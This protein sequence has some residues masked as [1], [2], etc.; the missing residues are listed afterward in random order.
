MDDTSEKSRHAKDTSEKRRHE[1]DSKQSNDNDPLDNDAGHI[2][3]QKNLQGSYYPKPLGD[4]LLAFGP[5]LASYQEHAVYL[6]DWNLN[7]QSQKAFPGVGNF[8]V[9][10]NHWYNGGS[11]NMVIGLHARATGKSN[12]VLGGVANQVSG[13]GVT[14]VGGVIV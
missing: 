4:E 8:I 5:F 1:K 9:G 7:I 14:I 12:S 3:Q 6:R 10:K 11:N 13:R 2:K